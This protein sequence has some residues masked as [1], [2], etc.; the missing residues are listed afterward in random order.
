[1]IAKQKLLPLW[2]LLSIYANGQEKQ[3]IVFSSSYGTC[4]ESRLFADL[5]KQEGITLLG[6][7]GY[8][9]LKELWVCTKI[10]SP[11]S[12][13][14]TILQFNKADFSGGQL[15]FSVM[16]VPGMEHIWIIPTQ[17]GMLEVPHLESDP[18]N[19]AAFNALL[20][21]IPKGRL[22][23]TGWLEIG[24]LYMAILGYKE[25]VPIRTESGDS[26]PCSSCNECSLSFSVGPVVKDEPYD[27]WTLIFACPSIGKPA[28]LTDVSRETI[29]PRNK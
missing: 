29:G 6:A 13:G 24:K 23:A 25:V 15:G 5:I 11:L 4:Q 10:E 28:V 7:Y 8:D 12:K 18:H 20:K 26:N 14:A 9:L 2:L 16:K 1:M 3:H 19:L 21:I 27:K 22:N 17:I